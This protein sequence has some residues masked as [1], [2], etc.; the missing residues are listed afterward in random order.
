M[1]GEK[2][3]DQLTAAI[4]NR[5]RLYELLVRQDFCLFVFRLAPFRRASFFHQRGTPTL[6]LEEIDKLQPQ[7][8]DVRSVREAHFYVDEAGTNQSLYLGVEILHPVI[9]AVAHRV[10]ECFSLGL[11]VLDI[12]TRPHRGFQNLEC[13]DA[14]A[15][16]AAGDQPLRYDESKRF[17]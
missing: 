7:V 14:T 6:R 5:A 10:E 3:I 2:G 1:R 4:R 8:A 15:A 11:A 13:G 17:G 16:V 9:I 12:F